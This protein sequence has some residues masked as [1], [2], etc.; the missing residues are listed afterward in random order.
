[1]VLIEVE[2]REKKSVSRKKKGRRG[3][4]K[5]RGQGIKKVKIW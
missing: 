4:K 3:S 5:R 1:M 2:R